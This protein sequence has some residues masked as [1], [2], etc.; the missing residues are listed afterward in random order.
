MIDLDIIKT[1]KDYHPKAK[2][3][4]YAHET[5]HFENM[6]QAKKWLDETYGKSKRSPMFR[7][8]IDGKIGYVIGFRNEQY[9][10]EKYYKY[11]EQH[12][13]EFRKNEVCVI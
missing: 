6:E 11:L 9:E 4:Q 2:W 7:D 5:E 13:I 8:N 10:N 1:S 3:C 12:W